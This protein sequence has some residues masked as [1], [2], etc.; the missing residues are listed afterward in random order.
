MEKKPFL[1][2][3]D[4]QNDFEISTGGNI[5]INESDKAFMCFHTHEHSRGLW[6][7]QNGQNGQ[8]QIFHRDSLHLIIE[9]EPR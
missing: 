1:D 5:W 2:F 7:E 9:V 8:G 6:Q 3:E 4:I